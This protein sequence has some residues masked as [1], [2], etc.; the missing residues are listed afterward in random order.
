MR[1]PDERRFDRIRLGVAVLSA[2]SSL[3]SD[4]RAQDRELFGDQA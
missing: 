1:E 3:T 2:S 4:T